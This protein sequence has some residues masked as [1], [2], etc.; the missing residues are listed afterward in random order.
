MELKNTMKIAFM[1]NQ[2]MLSQAMGYTYWIEVSVEM[3]KLSTCTQHL[4]H[5]RYAFLKAKNSSHWN[6]FVLDSSQRASHGSIPS[7]GQSRTLQLEKEKWDFSYAFFT[8]QAG[9]WL[10]GQ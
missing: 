2:Q 8:G 3:L 7:T 10:Y 6:T 9:R 1:C 5:I 4:S